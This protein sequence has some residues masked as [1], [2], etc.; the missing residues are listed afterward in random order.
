MTQISCN[1]S[2][3]AYFFTQTN[4]GVK[5]ETVSY[6]SGS[7]MDFVLCCNYSMKYK[8]QIKLYEE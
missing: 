4:G 6:G 3:T 8:L 5:M 1:D 7:E 2:V